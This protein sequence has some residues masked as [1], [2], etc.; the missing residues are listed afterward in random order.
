MTVFTSSRRCSSAFFRLQP[1]TPE[2]IPQAT[3]QQDAKLC[4]CQSCDLE[5]AAAH[6]GLRRTR[7]STHQGGR[8]GRAESPAAVVSAPLRQNDDGLHQ[9]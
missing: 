9:S 3:A 6:T 5:P 8:H 4:V 7:A 2:S 1:K